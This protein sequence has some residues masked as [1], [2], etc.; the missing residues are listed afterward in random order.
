MSMEGQCV[1]NN[2]VLSA[3]QNELISNYNLKD[4]IVLF[5][6][7]FSIYNDRKVLKK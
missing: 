5:L 4:K 6:V 3:Y 2:T 7:Y 1:K